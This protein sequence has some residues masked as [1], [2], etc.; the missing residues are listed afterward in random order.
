MKAS[1]A[2]SMIWLAGTRYFSV[3]SETLS[4]CFW[5]GRMVMARLISFIEGHGTLFLLFLQFLF[6]SVA[7]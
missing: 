1:S 6:D 3:S 5:V 2:Q 4:C 7:Y